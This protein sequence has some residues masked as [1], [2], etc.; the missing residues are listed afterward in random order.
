MRIIYLYLDYSRSLMIAEADV[1]EDRRERLVQRF[2]RRN[3]LNESSCLHYLLK[4]NERSQH[5]I[6]RLRSSQTL[7]HYFTRTEKFKKSFIP[8]SL[9]NY[10]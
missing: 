3:V 5:I 6:S 1:L 10:Q 8:F 4:P 2:F 9:N 7:E